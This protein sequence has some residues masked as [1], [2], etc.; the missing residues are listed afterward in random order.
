MRSSVE[1]ATLGAEECNSQVRELLLDIHCLLENIAIGPLLP[2]NNRSLIPV[3]CRAHALPET[4]LEHSR[5]STCSI[6]V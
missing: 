3:R 4:E 5:I 2:L 1:H 6:L